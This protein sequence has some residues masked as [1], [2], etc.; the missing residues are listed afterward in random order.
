MWPKR[1]KELRGEVCVT[2]CDGSS[3]IRASSARGDLSIHKPETF[4]PFKAPLSA[5]RHSTMGAVL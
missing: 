5:K 3:S 1:G 2:K 4:V